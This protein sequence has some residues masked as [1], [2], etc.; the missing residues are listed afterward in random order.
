MPVV[1]SSVDIGGAGGLVPTVVPI[2]LSP[3]LSSFLVL[4]KVLRALWAGL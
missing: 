4:V 3:P 1:A 2:V